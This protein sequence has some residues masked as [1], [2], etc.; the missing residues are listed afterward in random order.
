MVII[1]EFENQLRQD[2]R[3][4]DVNGSISAAI[5]KQDRKIWSNTFGPA[6]IDGERLANADTIYRV[7]SI[8]KSFTAFLMM[9]LVQD[10]TIE[11]DDPVE[12]YFPGI[13]ELDGYSDSTKITFRQLASHTSGLVREPALEKADSGSIEEW[14]E[15][16]LQSIA[17]TSFEA[18][19]GERF[20]YSNIGYGILGVALS[21]AMQDPFIEMIGERIF[22][23]L[24]MDNSFFAVPEHKLENLA[25][26]IGGGPFGETELDLEGPKKE[27]RGRGYKVPNGGVYS[28]T[29]DLAKFLS[30]VMGN[31]NILE[32]RYLELLYTKQTPETSNHGYGLGF[33]LYQDRSISIA[34][35]SGGVWG[36]SAHFGFEQEYGYGVIL[37]R[38]YNWGTTSWDIGPKVLLRKLVDFEKGQDSKAP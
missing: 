10:G 17:K 2:L 22:K 37:L 7:G 32:K 14:E 3:D 21:H 28:T 34:E 27:H 31:G 19:P 26:G 29:T 23:P 35:H 5:V 38:N 12:R 18:R 30:C 6:S 24:G 33:G 15:K 1:E 20:S 9:Q 11:L 36:Y 8:A 25:Q 16:V 13:R 4:D